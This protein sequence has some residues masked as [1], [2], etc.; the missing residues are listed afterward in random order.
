MYE[1][2]SFYTEAKIR[3]TKT[4]KITVTVEFP[5]QSNAQAE[6]AFIDRLKEIYLGK[7][8]KEING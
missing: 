5:M 8:E 7:M 3:K 6:Q 1:T 4:E 2:Y